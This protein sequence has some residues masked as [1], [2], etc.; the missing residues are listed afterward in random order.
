MTG[1]Q[2]I[3]L[4]W[5]I[6]GIGG[7]AVAKLTVRASGSNDPLLLDH[8][9]PTALGAG[10]VFILAGPMLLLFM[11]GLCIKIF[12]E[13]R[14]PV[15]NRAWWP[16]RA[17]KFP[18]TEQPQSSQ[19]V[20]SYIDHSPET[21]LCQLIGL[22]PPGAALL[23]DGVGPENWPMW[24]LWKTTEAGLLDIVEQYF[25]LCDGGLTAQEALEKIDAA[26]AEPHTASF[27]LNWTLRSYIAQRLANH[28]P[29]YLALGPET[30]DE[31]IELAEA[32]SNAKIGRN[33]TDRPYPPTEWL[34][35]RVDA[36]EIEA[37]ASLPFKDGGLVMITDGVRETPGTTVPIDRDWHRITLRMVP[38]DELWTFS[39]PPEYWQGLTGRMGVALMRNGHPIGHVTTM[40]N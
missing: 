2:W 21:L 8:D 25:W 40:M 39:S 14:L 1:W 37:K 31:A 17:M 22:R 30:L 16:A 32:W 6:L 26:R 5:I 18:D 3:C 23:R 13:G 36:S 10:L 34:K 15:S 4:S 11:L 38:G 24:M 19:T 12:S 27:G 9:W 35:A 28:D 33:K 20:S 29:S 7:L